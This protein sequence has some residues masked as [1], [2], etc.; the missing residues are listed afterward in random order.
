MHNS[1]SN[2]RT[3]Q[4]RKRDN[5]IY[6]SGKV[7]S[8]NVKEFCGA[9]SVFKTNHSDTLTLDFTRVV[10]AY[11]NGMLPIIATV[12][13][14]RRNG[15]KI[16][17][18]LPSDD[19]TRKLFRAVNW[20]HYLSPEL[21]QPSE[22]KHDRHLVTRYFTDEKDQKNA[23]DD[24][25][26]VIIRS[27]VLPRSI[28]SGLEW[29]INEIMDNVLN[30]S[31]SLIG[32]LVQATTYP[33]KGIIAFAVADA[34]RGILNS[35]REGIPTLRTDIQAMGEA[36]KAGVTRNSA[37]GQGNGL[38][39][40]LKITT[41]TGGSFD[42]TSGSGRLLSTAEETV[43][44]PWEKHEYYHGT[45]I[46]GQVK[47]K[48]DF[49]IGQALDFGTGIDYVPVDLIEMFYEMESQN[50]LFLKMKEET[51]GYGSRKSGLQIRTKIVNLLNA[52]P[53]YP[54]IID[55]E[56][57]PVTSSSFADEFMGKLFLKLG[58]ITFSAR[59]RNIGMEQLIKNLL[60][61]A[62]SQRLT[63]SIDD[64]NV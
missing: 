31:N 10:N 63:Q 29:S 1:T 16:K 61:K 45:L 26:D 32:G 58:G 41:L 40:T 3:T 37:Y 33:T 25:L 52:E 18:L 42:I 60:D 62:I 22:S 11:P 46:C 54:L 57:V 49:S 15:T 23:S 9:V 30:H 12:E 6:F 8:Y 59:I 51:T 39:G 44:K 55:W 19:N 28:I 64:D 43:P 2:T 48:E 35:L 7:N 21:F 17:I 24:L 50:A 14:L 4:F 47:I 34:G 5:V 56:G 38:A 36:V 53:T 20:A 13:K 27:M